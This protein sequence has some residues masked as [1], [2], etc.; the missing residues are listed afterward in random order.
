MLT[1]LLD[2]EISQQNSVDSNLYSS[3]TKPTSDDHRGGR[4]YEPPH[5]PW[6]I[7]A[8]P[9]GEEYCQSCL[10]DFATLP[11]NRMCLFCILSRI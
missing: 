2:N 10:K 6:N 8:D 5:V 4:N 7:S 1:L 3:T 9:I 11:V